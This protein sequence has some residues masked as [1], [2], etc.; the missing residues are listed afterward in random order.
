[1]NTN[2]VD[3]DVLIRFLSEEAAYWRYEAEIAQATLRKVHT[4][5]TQMVAPGVNLTKRPVPP[6][7]PIGTKYLVDGYLHIEHQ[8]E[9]WISAETAAVIEWPELWRGLQESV[10]H[11]VRVLPGEAA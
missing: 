11:I 10:E 2:D 1:M 7:P 3:A 6:E 9:G 8:T 5:V 4:I